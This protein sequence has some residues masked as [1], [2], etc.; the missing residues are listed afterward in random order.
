MIY[1][2]SIKKVTACDFCWYFNRAGRAI[3]AWNFTQYT[4]TSSFV[5][6]Y[7]WKWRNYLFQP[8]QPPFLSVPSVICSWLWRASSE[9]PVCWWWEEDAGL[10]ETD[11][12]TRR[13]SKWP[14]LAD[15]VM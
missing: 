4:V 12:V 14:P 1:R 3:F 11:R 9:Q 8:R 10:L 13:C 5:E 6:T 15:T 2:V 7:I